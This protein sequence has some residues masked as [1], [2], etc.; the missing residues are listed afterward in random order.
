MTTKPE[1]LRVL[2]VEDDEAHVELVRRAF[3]AQ[4]GTVDLHVA[5]SLKQARLQCAAQLPNLVIGDWLLP[6]GRGTELLP[7]PGTEAAFPVVIMT[8]H[9]NEQVAVDAMKAGALDY[10]VKTPENLADMAH[11]ADRALRVWRLILERRAA[12]AERERLIAELKQALAKVK[13]LHGLLPIC[14]ACKRIRDDQG[15]WQQ[16]ELY[17]TERS[18]A[19]FTHGVCPECARRI[20]NP[21]S[22]T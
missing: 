10:V 12:E 7:P 4:G 8:S 1:R 17:I 14:S 16:V 5:A 13:R 20:Y 21:A 15:Y 11:I 3:E 19:T 6:D 18:E 22:T 9:G 2:L